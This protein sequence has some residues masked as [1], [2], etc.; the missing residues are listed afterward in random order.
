M[1]ASPEAI[2]T[3]SFLIDMHLLLVVSLLLLAIH[4]VNGRF[5]LLIAI[6]FQ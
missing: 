5:L 4:L 6:Q 1:V 2:A 3:S